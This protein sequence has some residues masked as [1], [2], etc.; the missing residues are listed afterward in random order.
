MRD[1]VTV[2]AMRTR[3]RQGELGAVPAAQASLERRLD[4]ELGGL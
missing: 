2:A 3:Q 1:I 4:E